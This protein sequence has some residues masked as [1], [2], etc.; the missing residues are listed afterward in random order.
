MGEVAAHYGPFVISLMISSCLVWLLRRRQPGTWVTTMF[1]MMLAI[2]VWNAAYIGEISTPNLAY[3]KFYINVE[4]IGIVAVPV[5][6]LIFTIQF[7]SS[8][9]PINRWLIIALCVVPLITV[10][11]SLTNDAHGLMRTIH[12]VRQVGPLYI[13]DKS[14]GLWFLVHLIFSY[15]LMG[16]GTILLLKSALYKRGMLFWQKVCTM[17]GLGLPW[18]ANFLYLF[19]VNPIPG[20]DLTPLFFSLAG[21]ALYLALFPMRMIDLL[22]IARG[23]VMD[24]L[25]D[26][27]L[28]ENLQQQIVDLN[29][30]ALDLF[31]LKREQ[32]IGR[33]LIDVFPSSSALITRFAGVI[34]G[35]EEIQTQHSW[36][37]VSISQLK[38][39]KGRRVG[40]L[41]SLRN[42]SNRKQAEKELIFLKDDL[43]KVVQKRTQQLEDSQSRLQVSQAQMEAILNNVAAGIVVLDRNGRF[44]Q[45][46]DTWA[47]MLGYQ[48]EELSSFCSRDIVF[49]KEISFDEQWFMLRTGG[50]AVPYRGEERFV[51]QDGR[52]FWGDLSVTPVLDQQGELE[53]L[54][55]VVIDITDRKR[56]EQQML[57]NAMHD[58]LTSLP[59][60]NLFIDR[61]SQELQRLSV[62]GESD[63]SVLYLDFDHFKDINDSLGHNFGDHLLIQ[64]AARLKKIFLPTDTFARV[65]GDEFLILL[66]KE[67]EPDRAYHTAE[68][69]LSSLKI[70]FLLDNRQVV[71]SA[72]IGILENLLGYQKVEDVMRDAD[73]AMY[74]AKMRGRNRFEVFDTEMRDQAVARLEQE[75]GLR[76]ALQQNQLCLDFQPIISLANQKVIG[77]EALVRWHSPQRGVIFPSEFIPLAEETGLIYALGEWVLEEACRNMVAWQKKF[78]TYPPLSI[79]VNL[80][81]RQFTSPGIKDQV[82]RILT[83]TGLSPECLR[84]EITEGMLL[85]DFESTERMLI[86]LR[87]MGVQTVIDDFGTGYSSLSYLHSFPISALKID[88]SFIS[89]LD[90]SDPSQSGV[91]IVRAI[92]AMARE[93]DI[94]VVA[95]G[96]ETYLQMD[97]L[98]QMSCDYGQ[99]YLISRPIS[100]GSVEIFLRGQTSA[101]TDRPTIPIPSRDAL[102]N[103][104]SR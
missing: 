56:Y 59:N 66:D 31:E 88:R 57:H 69:I 37:G 39:H 103:Y 99:G 24:N 78:P 13:M 64:S 52:L 98:R 80:S 36:Y 35:Y 18:L 16:I 20:L 71:V 75:I 101:A 87:E 74:R 32:V 45:Y 73:I 44:L 55:C 38:D 94:K 29:P 102:I 97:I 54:L 47:V 17:V 1:M 67:R 104:T 84:I 95:E 42:I 51:C 15:L 58:S 28:V 70:P 82:A 86:A 33:R 93:M 2:S 46:N 60:R 65:G 68:Q 41:L 10:T 76:T 19:N 77:F 21:L 91:E 4:Y 72:S 25:K 40:R 90:S 22:P 27:V 50:R 100:K 83:E 61:L 89:R 6:W 85:D 81:P 43:E 30:A 53:S 7:S 34:D 63:F 12:G 49:G 26:L 3:M 92:L 23:A 11:L 5:I 8:G 79:S 9:R 96:I 14:Y 62:Y 48:R